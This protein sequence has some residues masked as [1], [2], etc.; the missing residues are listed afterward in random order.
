MALET[1]ARK[2]ARERAETRKRKAGG[3]Q[4]S[5]DDAA[6]TR[7]DIKASLSRNLETVIGKDGVDSVKRNIKGLKGG[8]KR[9]ETKP[10]KPVKAAAASASKPAKKPASKPAKKPA[11]KPANKPAKKPETFAQKFAKERK[12]QGAGGTFTYKGKK[13]TTDRDDDKRAKSTKGNEP[14]SPVKAPEK[15]GFFGKLGDSFKKSTKRTP[16]RPRK[17]L[18]SAAKSPAKMRKYKSDMK[19][20]RSSQE[21]S[22]G[23]AS[24][25]RVTAKKPTAKKPM[26][27]ASVKKRMPRRP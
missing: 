7:S 8:G 14:R 10:P 1:P 25:G 13:F 23:K 15:K 6:Q 20:W 16:G 11:N 27:R 17:P 22:K 4:R 5:K 24:G 12:A 3:R 9:E 21:S 2:R 26:A 19:A 18:G